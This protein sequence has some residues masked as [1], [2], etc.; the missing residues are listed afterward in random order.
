MITI[1]KKEVVKL[2]IAALLAVLIDC[3]KEIAIFLIPYNGIVEKAIGN[4]CFA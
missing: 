3:R 2:A 4:N 1:G